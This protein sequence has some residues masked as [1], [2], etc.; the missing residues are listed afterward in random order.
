MLIRVSPRW[1]VNASQVRAIGHY[2]GDETVV[3]VQ[4]T[5]GEETNFE[6]ESQIV[7]DGIL[8]DIEEVFC[9]KTLFNPKE[10]E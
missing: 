4:Y 7:R 1:M 8:A 2:Q 3:T 10:E 6:C 9:P 5:D